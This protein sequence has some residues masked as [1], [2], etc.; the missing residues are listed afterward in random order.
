M[1]RAPDDS[2][3]DY[4][5]PRAAL[6]GRY[7]RCPSP[8]AEVSIRT[9]ILRGGPVIAAIVVLFLAVQIRSWWRPTP[10]VV[11]YFS[12]ARSVWSG[13]GLSNLGNP[14]LHYAPGYPLLI[15]PAFL[16]PERTFLGIS[17]LRFVMAS[18]TAACVYLWMRRLV[19]RPAAILLSLLVV[20]NVSFLHY[21]RTPLSD[22]PMM[23]FLFA[24]ALAL[25][26]I[27]QA[28]RSG[29]QIAWTVAA[30]S[31]L[32]AA[33][34]TR[35]S[36]IT[37]AAGFAV[38][39]LFAAHRRAMG[40][41]KALLAAAVMPL[42][43]LL[44]AVYLARR[45]QAF[46]GDSKNP[47]YLDQLQPLAHGFITQISTGL[48]LRISEIGRLLIPGMWN[49]HGRAGN[50]L[51]INLLLYLPL[52]VLVAIGWF[53][54]ARRA[55]DPLLWA[56]PFYAAMYI[57]WPFDQDTRFFTPIL[58]ILAV[59]LWPFIRLL[60]TA[61]WRLLAA[62]CAIHLVISVALWINESRRIGREYAQSWPALQQ[63]A[64]RITANQKPA[65][66]PRI[67][68][69]AQLWLQFLI[70]RRLESAAPAVPDSP[71]PADVQWLVQPAVS[72]RADSDFSLEQTAGGFSLY[73]RRPGSEP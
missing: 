19:P 69:N 68:P 73:R 4:R 10:D 37:L 18:I 65:A 61:R 7:P 48:H 52:A 67:T 15:S 50:W 58:P 64:A 55:N 36:A 51:D 46:A 71:L 6:P 57:L 59:S 43:A 42:P 25:R 17:M 31:L 5:A 70:D 11:G 38:W 47:T 35:Q 62:L 34:V 27:A 30:A 8:P 63:I 41:L 40:R 39:A 45:D 53:R 72:P 20:F 60:R 22:L 23:M 3:L 49:A 33:T 1:N 56:A 13:R 28:R 44:A 16:F 54:L 26:K 24:A 9:F 32:L 21:Y 2:A 14:M 12:I 29:P 66:A